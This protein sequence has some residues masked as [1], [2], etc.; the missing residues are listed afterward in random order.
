MAAGG[1]HGWRSKG[2]GKGPSPMTRQEARQV[3]AALLEA[4][5]RLFAYALALT[6]DRGQA[7]DLLQDCAVKVLGAE[8]APTAERALRVW[9]HA[10]LRHA[11]IDRLRRQRVVVFEPLRED[12]AGQPVEYPSAALRLDDVMALRDAL[13]GLSVP[14]RDIVALVDLAGF[15][16][17][18][19]AEILAVPIGTVM[20]R[21]SRARRA[22][23]E[24]LAPAAAAAATK[25][26][27]VR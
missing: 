21:V 24:A 25:R 1:R 17:Q 5:P 3:R 8:G 7:E 20:S 14:H 22:L 9:F 19:A 11:W 12:D 2:P 26:K 15:S 16:Y 27:L 6:R 4:W 23:L 10:I 13:A 18:E